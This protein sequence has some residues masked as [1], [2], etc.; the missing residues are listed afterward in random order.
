MCTCAYAMLFIVLYCLYIYITTETHTL[1]SLSIHSGLVPAPAID[2]KI[3]GCSNPIV[4]P[5]NAQFSMQGL[6]N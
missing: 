2:T 3:H 5:S 6:R 4:Y 1:L